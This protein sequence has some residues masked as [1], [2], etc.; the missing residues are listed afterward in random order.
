MMKLCSSWSEKVMNRKSSSRRV[1]NPRC[2]TSEIT[3][4]EILAVSSGVRRL[5]DL[6]GRFGGGHGAARD[7][8]YDEGN[9]GNKRERD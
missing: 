8:N 9:S 7:H 1:W 4:L 5:R 3:I 2:S 6:G